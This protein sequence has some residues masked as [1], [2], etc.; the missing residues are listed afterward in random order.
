MLETHSQSFKD[1]IAKGR[2]DKA[3]EDLAIFMQ[4]LSDQRSKNDLAQ[5]S[6]RWKSNERANNLGTLASTE[7]NAEKNKIN[8]ALIELLDEINS[9]TKKEHN[10]NQTHT[11]ITEA[12]GTAELTKGDMR[13]LIYE[14]DFEKAFKLVLNKAKNFGEDDIY[15]QVKALCE[16]WDINN[17][18]LDLN[19]QGSP[20]FTNKQNSIIEKIIQL[21]NQM[22][23]LKSSNSKHQLNISSPS[24]SSG[25]VNSAWKKW[26]IVFAGI[27]AALGALAEFT[28]WNIRDFS[29]AHSGSSLQLTVYIQT[30]DGKPVSE[31]QNK[32][33]I[34][35]DFGN[36]RRGLLIGENGRTNLGEIPEKFKNQQVPIVFQADGYE[37]VNIYKKYIMDGKPIYIFV[38]RDKS[39]GLVQG[40]VKDRSGE[41]FIP[42]AL[43]MLDNDTTITTDSL[44]RFRL[45]LPESKQ[46][47]RYL[48]TVKKEG[49]KS[50]TDFYLPRTG[51]IEIRINK[52]R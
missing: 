10:T 17:R 2:S 38:H 23:E 20:D 41:I 18:I 22:E 14:R 49:F 34:F 19:P 27:L 46:R 5:L 1:L 33:K 26:A 28:G 51:S 11:E 29:N 15:Y 4:S 52:N 45:Q 21:N 40:I 50:S 47:E 39:L 7:Y 8:K 6:A 13:K 30:A 36:D 24:H 37:P 44:G 35:V 43:V 31:L 16:S 32:G 42:N 3:I 9:E 25:E 48:I 12:V